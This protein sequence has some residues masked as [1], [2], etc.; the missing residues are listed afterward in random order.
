MW[1]NLAGQINK[2]SGGILTKIGDVVA[3]VLDDHVEYTD[4][5][6]EY[7]DYEDFHDDDDSNEDYFLE[8][9]QYNFQKEQY[10]SNDKECE[11]P[12]KDLDLIQGSNDL[13]ANTPGKNSLNMLSNVGET[14]EDASKENV[15][16]HLL[17][18]WS[19][20]NQRSNLVTSSTRG[21]DLKEEVSSYNIGETPLDSSNENQF[22]VAGY[23][24]NSSYER[25]DSYL[26]KESID[27][28]TAIQENSDDE[29]ILN[30]IDA[31][32]NIRV[33]PTNING[34]IKG[35]AIPVC[36]NSLSLTKNTSSSIFESNHLNSSLELRKHNVTE[37]SN[38]HNNYY[39]SN[40]S[41]VLDENIP[42]CSNCSDHRASD[43]S[44]ML[45]TVQEGR[46]D[47]G[48]IVSSAVKINQSLHYKASHKANVSPQITYNQKSDISSEYRHTSS[49]N[50]NSQIIGEKQRENEPLNLELN[51]ENDVTPS[52]HID[53]SVYQQML[54]QF[55]EDKRLISLKYEEQVLLRENKFK[56]EN[57]E[58]QKLVEKLS[59]DCQNIQKDASSEFDKFKRRKEHEIA[60]LQN[61][62]E[63]VTSRA[64]KVEI[65]LDEKLNEEANVLSESHLKD[66]RSLEDAEV[67]IQQVSRLLD[68]RKYEID[69]MKKSASDMRSMLSIATTE[70]HQMERE[71]D[72]RKK[73]VHEL[74][75]ALD[76]AHVSLDEQEGALVALEN[77][78]SDM[79][80]LQMELRLIKE[81]HKREIDEMQTK[82]E[83]LSVSLKSACSERDAA[84][85][86][87][88]DTQRQLVQVLADLQLSQNDHERAISSCENMQ[89]AIEAFQIE[90]DGE[91]ALLDE[92]RVDAENALKAAHEISLE[93]LRESTTMRMK[94]VERAANESVKNSMNEI[95]Q[96]EKRLDEAKAE[97][98]V[99]RNSLDEAIS[100]LQVTQED[101]IDRSLMKNI[102]LDWISK[103]SKDRHDILEVIASLLHFSDEEKE[104][105]GLFEYIPSG[106][107]GRV[108]GAVAAPLPPSK[109]NLDKIE[110][111]DLREKWVN[112]L[113]AESS[114]DGK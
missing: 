89:R 104:K 68:D 41:S 105:V 53:G 8:D 79:G 44:T 108:V 30:E 17:K 36:H 66:R 13:D 15:S 34:I 62:L 24:S 54:K 72:V 74:K 111:D 70:N 16:K 25:D 39:L 46:N 63:A 93:A 114:E 23:N 47:S 84:A 55:E 49:S 28:Q 94:E 112:F 45:S 85:Q 110:G 2:Q 77:E 22:H 35:T 32:D 58:L 98:Q 37:D 97:N 82:N 5:E 103:K 27:G 57:V 90:R 65:A 100:R 106:I 59:I 11:I 12:V 50:C 51:D 10:V 67:K 43:F 33:C 95:M 3:P 96:L 9:D 26:G 19:N 38:E 87:A 86:N 56:S 42:E 69:Q 91:Y 71:I 80:G 60:Q 20:E 83:Q 78:N 6:E 109:L 48:G 29:A 40:S 31:C 7:E 1:G 92:Q 81:A 75:Q 113:M 73:E 76:D 4:S 102:L 14:S 99:T 61:L 21:D 18:S 88:K 64:E 52:N 107:A 101:V